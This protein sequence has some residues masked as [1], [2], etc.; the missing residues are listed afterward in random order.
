MKQNTMKVGILFSGGKDS[1]YALLKAKEKEDVRCLIT[2]VSEN[3]ESYM[4][5]TPN[6]WLASLQAEAIG[7]PLI[8]EKTE[9]RKEKELEDLKKAV[10]RAHQE[11]EIQGI[12]T[13][14]IQSVYQATRIQRICGEL[15][16]WCYNPLWLHDPLKLLKEMVEKGFVTL[17]S[18][19][20][21][22]AF[23]ANWLGR[24]IDKKVIEELEHLQK[25]YRISPSGEGGEIETTVLDAPFFKKRIE[26][27]DYEIKKGNYF[28]AMKPMVELQEGHELFTFIAN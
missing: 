19:V 15:E 17:I 21:A 12:V 1:C 27:L 2:I 5:H 16:L 23:A 24:I 9:G 20:F 22:E 28:G 3:M 10:E 6:I 11:F 8:L 18:G 13:G 7:L 14:A 25:R 4:F 26:I